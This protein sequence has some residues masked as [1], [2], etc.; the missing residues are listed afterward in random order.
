MSEAYLE[1]T[2]LTVRD[3]DHTAKM[4][5]DLFDWRIR[6]SGDA[7]HNGYTVHVGG[8]RS[9][10]ALFTSTAKPEKPVDSF[11]YQNGLNH[12]GIVV[13]DIDAAEKTI[14]AAGFKTRSHADYEP[15]RRFY[16]EDRD[17]LEFE[18]ISYNE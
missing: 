16:F 8:T 9:Y 11:H 5:V 12:L 17:G 13:N 6:W 1:H 7:I 2:N 18:V 4:L 3:P 15:G 10:L 14:L